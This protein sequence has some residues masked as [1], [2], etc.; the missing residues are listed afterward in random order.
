LQQFRSESG[1]IFHLVLDASHESEFQFLQG[2]ARLFG[3]ASPLRSTIDLKE[4]LEH[5]LFQKA[6]E[7]GKTVV[8]L[9]DE[10]QKISIENLEV[11]RML[12]NFETNEFKMLQLVIMGQTE[13]LQ[14]I[15]RV[16][17][18]M[19]RVALKYTLNPL[20]ENEVG[21]MIDFRLSQAG[22]DRAVPLFTEGA[23]RLVYEHTGGY[24]RRISMLCHDALEAAVMEDRDQID[25]NA[26]EQLLLREAHV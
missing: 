12:L 18:F 25:A 13:F 9:I 16:R 2:L 24:P 17:N 4:A 19:D 15:K 22:Y 8:L 10:A 7:E 23:K 11:L 5:Y 21:A 20:D 14:R 6:V 3:I 1:C 26:I